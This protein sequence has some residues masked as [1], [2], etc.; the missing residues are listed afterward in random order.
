MKLFN[1]PNLDQKDY[2]K[3]PA[4]LYTG[5]ITKV[6][7]DICFIDDMLIAKSA[8]SFAIELNVDDTVSYIESSHGAFIV[9]L[10][11]AAPRDELVL[12]YKVGNKLTVASESIEL[13]AG[14]SVA[15]RSLN[16]ITLE[17]LNSVNIHCKNWLQSASDS[18]INVTSTWIQKCRQSSVEASELLR[19]DAGSQVIT[20]N[21]DLR[22]DAKRIN[23]G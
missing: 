6:E 2:K 20:A 5:V 11:I 7:G 23:M 3:T 1:Q 13:V 18:V 22:L 16:E 17:T 10:L 21:E 14:K 8:N 19:T 12:H 15:V 4:G 9:D